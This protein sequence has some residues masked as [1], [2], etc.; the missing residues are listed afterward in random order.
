MSLTGKYILKIYRRGTFYFV[1]FN[2]QRYK[3]QDIEKIFIEI[4]RA[5]RWEPANRVV[6]KVIN[7]YVSVWLKKR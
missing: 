1:K 5:F 4:G 2:D 6:R 3:G 7:H